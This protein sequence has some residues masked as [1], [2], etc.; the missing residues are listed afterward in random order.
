MTTTGLDRIEDYLE[1]IAQEQQRNQAEKTQRILNG[2]TFTIFLQYNTKLDN[3]L[4]FDEFEIEGY[5]N[6]EMIVQQYRSIGHSIGLR[7]I[8]VTL[9]EQRVKKINFKY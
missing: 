1:T 2:Q 3:G 4:Y 8:E 9:D 5:S 6:M 7:C